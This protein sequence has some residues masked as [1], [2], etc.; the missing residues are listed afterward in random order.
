MADKYTY[1]SEEQLMQRLR[2]LGVTD[3]GFAK[4]LKIAPDDKLRRIIEMRKAIRNLEAKKAEQELV[5]EAG[6]TE[7]EP[8]EEGITRAKLFAWVSNATMYL[9]N[10][11]VAGALFQ[12]SE[13]V[14]FVVQGKISPRQLAEELANHIFKNGD[15]TKPTAV[16]EQDLPD[17]ELL[18]PVPEEPERHKPEPKPRPQPAPKPVQPPPEPTTPSRNF[19]KRPDAIKWVARTKGW[20]LR[21]AAYIF[22]VDPWLTT[23]ELKDSIIAV[24][25]DRYGDS[26]FT[27]LDPDNLPE[28]SDE[29]ATKVKQILDARTREWEERMGKR[30]SRRPS[31]AEPKPAEELSPA[32]TRMV[33]NALHDLLEPYFEQFRMAGRSEEAAR[34]AEEAAAEAKKHAE[35]AGSFKREVDHRADT[36]NNYAEN[37]RKSA[38][39]AIQAATEVSVTVGGLMQQLRGVEGQL[40]AQILP[41]PEEPESRPFSKAKAIIWLTE[42]S[43]NEALLRLAAD[44]LGW[45]EDYM[46]ASSVRELFDKLA[47]HIGSDEY[48]ANPINPDT[49]SDIPH[50]LL[51]STQAAP[52]APAGEEEEEMPEWLQESEEALQVELEEPPADDIGQVPSWVSDIDDYVPE[53]EK[54]GDDTREVVISGK[55]IHP[56]EHPAMREMDAMFGNIKHGMWVWASSSPGDKNP[57]LAKVVEERGGFE[58]SRAWGAETPGGIRVTRTEELLAPARPNVS[59]VSRAFDVDSNLIRQW[60]ARPEADLT[61]QLT[62][63]EVDN[64]DFLSKPNRRSEQ[65]SSQYVSGPR[66]G[67]GSTG[68][69]PE[70]EAKG[71]RP[72]AKGEEGGLVKRTTQRAKNWFTEDVQFGSED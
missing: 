32:L 68:Q 20:S 60:I 46:G 10:P 49:F 45:E 36:A 9:D 3:A 50:W 58:G 21:K 71:Q 62:Q 22:G 17:L 42:N 37:A 43:E 23:S 26:D 28:L 51:T 53:G 72:E 6:P 44:Q 19:L 1:Y 30:P 13:K 70:P 64:I 59:Q 5:A 38:N 18:A 67:R 69:S 63:D 31:A 65:A 47:V 57:F 12:I 4:L 25:R 48:V 34:K 29:V 66:S 39:A 11:R 52:P 8:A 35:A 55:P 56:P 2:E 7:A 27:A 40:G 15:T 61:Y 14:G 24:I 54:R 16:M 33:E 41:E